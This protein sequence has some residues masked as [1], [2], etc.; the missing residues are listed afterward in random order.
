MQAKTQPLPLQVGSTLGTG[1]H[2]LSSSLLTI[3]VLLYTIMNASLTPVI[4]SS[5]TY[6]PFK[7]WYGF[8]FLPGL[9]GTVD[10]Q[11]V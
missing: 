4:N 10:S 5:N 11:E 2:T 8:C 1:V 6:F 7:C 9:F 3:S